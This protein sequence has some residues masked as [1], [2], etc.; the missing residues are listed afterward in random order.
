MSKGWEKIS[1]GENVNQQ[2]LVIYVTPREPE[3]IWVGTATGGILIS[4]NG[5]ET[6]TKIPG[7]PNGI[8]DG[9]P[10]SAIAENPKKKGYMYVGTTQTFYM[11]KDAGK[12]WTR[13]GGNL[14]LGNYASILVNPNDGDEVYIASALDVSDGIF[15]SDNAGWD[16]KRI[17]PKNRSVA[18][19]RV[20]A[21]MFD[22]NN[23]NRIFVGTHSSGIYRVDQSDKAAKKEAN[24]DPST[25]TRPR[26]SAVAN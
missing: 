11:S 19:S 2:I 4:K 9:V 21:M 8:P 17:D 20:W 3:T 23:P 1:F 24:D 12:T 13:R 18:S 14:P 7:G 25:T 15:Y 5:G 6:W 16:W 26:I 22:P 10:I